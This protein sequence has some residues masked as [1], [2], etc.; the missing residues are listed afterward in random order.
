MKNLK[1]IF[2]SPATFLDSLDKMAFKVVRKL[3]DFFNDASIKPIPFTDVEKEYIAGMTKKLSGENGDFSIISHPELLKSPHQIMIQESRSG[4]CVAI[5]KFEGSHNKSTYS[6]KESDRM[7]ACT[8]C[9]SIEG[10][11]S[12]MEYFSLN[13]DPAV[14]LQNAYKYPYAFFNREGVNFRK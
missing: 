8:M 14:A 11:G 2:Q 10:V 6:I 5:L 13:K 7:N 9:N 3:Y 1:D 12:L 4:R